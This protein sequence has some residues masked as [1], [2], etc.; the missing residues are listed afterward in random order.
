MV[1]HPARP[2]V[3]VLHAYD[4]TIWKVRRSRATDIAAVILVGWK[5]V[6]LLGVPRSTP[7]LFICDKGRQ[8]CPDPLNYMFDSQLLR[9][10]YNLAAITGGVELRHLVLE[11]T[12]G[13]FYVPAPAE[14]EPSKFSEASPI[15]VPAESTRIRVLRWR[16]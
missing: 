6:A 9:T 4:S 13:R 2:V 16:P 12:D 3:L 1:H 8:D 14:M 7:A 10:A 11:P 5:P 15:S